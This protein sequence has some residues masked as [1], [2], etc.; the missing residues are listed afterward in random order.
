[1]NKKQQN[2]MSE[3]NSIGIRRIEFL[4]TG[5]HT[6]RVREEANIKRTLDICTQFPRVHCRIK[7]YASAEGNTIK[8][9]KLPLGRC[10][11]NISRAHRGISVTQIWPKWNNLIEYWWHLVKTLERLHINSRSKVFL[12]LKQL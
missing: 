2:K 6:K 3:M 5:N 11:V 7:I 12:E 9:R 4:K 8:P 1:M 10:E